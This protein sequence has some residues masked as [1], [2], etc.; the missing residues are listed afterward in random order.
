MTSLIHIYVLVCISVP[1]NNFLVVLNLKI[2]E[3]MLP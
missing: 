1:I 3:K 2:K